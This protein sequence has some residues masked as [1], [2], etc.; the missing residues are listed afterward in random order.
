MKRTGLF[1]FMWIIV[2]AASAQR[3]AAAERARV[4]ALRDSLSSII[5][6]QKEDTNEVN[7]LAEI[8]YLHSSPDS[9]LIY[10]E[11][12]IA[13]A[14]SLHDEKGEADCLYACGFLFGSLG[15]YSQCI[16]YTLRALEIFEK[17]QDFRAIAEV[18]LIL[19]GTYRDLG[20]SE[21]ALAYALSGEELAESHNLIS[22]YNFPGHRMA[23]LFLAEIAK[24][25]LDM[26][27][28]DSSLFFTKKAIQQNELFQNTVWNFPLYLMGRIQLARGNYPEASKIFRQALSLAVSNHFPWDTLQ[29]FSGLAKYYLLT[30]KPDSAIYYS[31]I[32]IRNRNDGET[33]YVL[34]TIDDLASAY[35]LKGEKDSAIRYIEFR[36]FYWDSISSSKKLR[37]IQNLAFNLK[38]KHQESIATQKRYQEQLRFYFLAA[39]SLIILL[40]AVFLWRNVRQ[41]QKAYALLQQQKNETEQQKLKTEKALGELKDTQT[42]LIQSEKMAS[43]GVLTSGIAHE[44]QN[45]LNFVNNFSEVNTEL[46]RELQEEMNKGNLEDAKTIADEIGKNE[47]KINQHGK[48][49]DAIVKAM[50]QHARPTTGNKE[51]T[52]INQLTE[53]Y[54]RLAF[55]G[56]RTKEKSFHATIQTDFDPSIGNIDIVPGEIGRVLLNVFNNAF[57]AMNEMSG[58]SSSSY[59]PTISVITRKLT[60]SVEI[61][62][63]DNGT[64]I[65]QNTQNKIFQPFFTTKSPGQGTGLGL[66]LSYDIIKAHGG[67]IKLETREGVYTE[68]TIIL[69]INNVKSSVTN[70]SDS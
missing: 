4:V 34:E 41:R 16:Y 31:K 50:L 21:S 46:I 56:M 64:G 12:G 67:D 18:K 10:G 29:I 7:A 32:V 65:P 52:D 13:L 11:R 63:K 36:D 59:E 62:V 15:N 26:N 60:H 1:F 33:S 20:D 58:I 51:P 47:G 68:F 38:L 57:Y 2:S 42:Q 25:Y 70:S 24:T 19:Q 44:I 54:L 30:G 8:A 5:N 6:L 14:R 9:G 17:L 27:Q 45:P 48:R 43:L 28:I 37:D 55:L 69:P 40:V 49:A 23:P 35:K 39:G 61:R 3:E 22:K 66:S 53:E